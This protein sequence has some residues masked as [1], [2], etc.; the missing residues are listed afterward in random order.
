MRKIES[1]RTRIRYV[2]AR[3]RSERELREAG[4]A[5]QPFGPRS[6]ALGARS[7]VLE[8]VDSRGPGGFARYRLKHSFASDC[9][10]GNLL[11]SE[12]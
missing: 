1:A 6:A 7:S 5:R 4:R 11:S 9:V 10:D 12:L 8:C 3:A 2:F